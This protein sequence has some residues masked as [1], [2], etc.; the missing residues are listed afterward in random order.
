MFTIGLL[1]GARD[2]GAHGA[3]V[4]DLNPADR[5]GATGERVDHDRHHYILL[6]IQP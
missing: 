5:H 4:L 1:S 6:R 2:G 3:A